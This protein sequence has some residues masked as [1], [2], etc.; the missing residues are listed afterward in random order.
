MN[1][2]DLFEIFLVNESRS[3]RVFWVFIDT[4]EM[5][6]FPA[7]G[8]FANSDASLSVRPVSDN[9]GEN[10]FE[11]PVQFK[12]GA[13]SSNNAVGL[14]V[15]IDSNSIENV[16]LRD[17]WEAQFANFP[18]RKGPRLDQIASDLAPEGTINYLANAFNQVDNQRQGWFSSMSFGIETSNGF[19]GITWI[20]E[21]N[22]Q[23]LIRPKL[24]FFVAT[25]NFQSN[26]LAD[27]SLISR[28]AQMVTESD[29]DLGKATVTLEMD[30]TFSVRPGAPS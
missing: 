11:I 8:V 12:L 16:K 20:P 10:K 27:I 26:V 19:S 28:D 30:G 14:D 3:S 23:F 7:E 1:D 25:G 9:P 24:T 29:F 6:Q 2:V 18:P 15:R 13:G 22:T 5:S 4:P 21:P 17:T